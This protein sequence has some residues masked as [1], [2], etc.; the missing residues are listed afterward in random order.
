MAD[1][2]NAS[3]IPK[4]SKRPVKQI[5]TTRRIYLLSYLSYVLFFGSLLATGGIFFYSIQVNNDLNASREAL[6]AQRDRFSSEQITAVRALEK[7]LLLAEQLLNSLTAPSLIFS[8]IES[9]L[10]ENMY[11]TNF[12]YEYNPNQTSKITLQGKAKEFN[13]LLYQRDVFNSSKLFDNSEV[14]AFDYSVG[15]DLGDDEDGFGPSSIVGLLLE[16]EDEETIT[17]TFESTIT[18]DLIS[19]N[20]AASNIP[21]NQIISVR[22][23]NEGDAVVESEAET[24]EETDTSDEA[25][26][27]DEPNI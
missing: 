12:N 16:D 2:T 1:S 8:D 9:A 14:T 17:F 15:V 13:Q 24:T 22:P 10:A 27:S 23:N 7:K 20:P 6:I 5:R 4:N 11:L 3:F 18:N 26:T 21:E 19:Y 25:V